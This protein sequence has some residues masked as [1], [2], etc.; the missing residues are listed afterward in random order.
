VVAG[1]HLGSC[2]PPASMPEKDNAHRLT[3]MGRRD[4]IGQPRTLQ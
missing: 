2:R 1:N 4:G 3:G